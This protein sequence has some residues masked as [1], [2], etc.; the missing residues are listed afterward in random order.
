MKKGRGKVF[1][2]KNDVKITKKGCYRST[3]FELRKA[4]VKKYVNL[5]K[6]VQK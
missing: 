4:I 6:K 1:S 3:F 2:K 5:E